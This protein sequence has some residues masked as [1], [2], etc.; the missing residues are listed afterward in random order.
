[1]K[2]LN[3]TLLL[4]CLLFS[5]TINAQIKNTGQWRAGLYESSSNQGLERLS[6]V[7]YQLVLSGKT[8]DYNENVKLLIRCDFCVVNGFSIILIDN[9]GNIITLGNDVNIRLQFYG[10]DNY[11]GMNA[12]SVIERSA[13]IVDSEENLKTFITYLIKGNFSMTLTNNYKKYKF[14]VSNESLNFENVL[15]NIQELNN[16][17]E[18]VRMLN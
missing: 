8:I 6:Q 10:K 9:Y 2:L 12:D 13:C 17:F 7:Y 16:E 3:K 18:K 15:R 4:I 1:M 11:H 14:N 5:I